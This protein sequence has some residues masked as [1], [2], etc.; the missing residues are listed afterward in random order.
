MASAPT[1]LYPMTNW[2]LTNYTYYSEKDTLLIEGV[3]PAILS[4]VQDGTSIIT[5]HYQYRITRSGSVGA[6]SGFTTNGVSIGDT[7]EGVDRVP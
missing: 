2:S 3:V 7:V 4:E 6:W 5:V 1:I